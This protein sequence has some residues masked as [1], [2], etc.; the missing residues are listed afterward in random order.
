M[1]WMSLLGSLAGVL[2]VV[3]LA[4]WL[5][6]GRATPLDDASALRI[7]EETFTGH[8]F[9]ESVVDREGRAAL[10]EGMAGEAALI[11]AHGDKWVARLLE[12][13]ASAQAEGERLIVSP[14]ET[15]F[16]ATTLALGPADAA[17]WAAKL[18]KASHA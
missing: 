6:L 2:A 8:R 16:G 1:T 9:R 13:P 3:A 10:V 18:G 12:L 14:S 5:G 4:K 7:A 17:R 15:M 11:R